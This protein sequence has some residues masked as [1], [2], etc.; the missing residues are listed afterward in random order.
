MIGMM[1]PSVTATELS[2][3]IDYKIDENFNA[4]FKSLDYVKDKSEMKDRWRKQL[5][6]SSI[7]TY[8]NLLE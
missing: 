8:N 4:D 3:T 6:F 7:E 2:T 1:I 5:K